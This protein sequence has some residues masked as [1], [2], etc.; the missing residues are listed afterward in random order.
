MTELPK[1]LP[2]PFSFSAMMSQLTGS[3]PSAPA[4]FEPPV[5]TPITKPLGESTIGVLVSCGVYHST[6]PPFQPL[7]DLSYRL[8]DRS[9]PIEE[10]T[11]G[12]PAAIRHFALQDLNVAYPRDRLLELEAEGIF[13]RL[14]NENVSILGAISTLSDL[15]LTTVPQI[16]DEF[17]RQGVDLVLLLPF[18]PA[19]HTSVSLVARA[20][21]TRG[22]PT[23]MTNCNWEAG[24]AIKA[25]RVAFLDFPMGCPAGKPN[26]PDLQRAVLRDT[27]RAA[28]GFS[29]P[30]EM[31]E[32]PYQW[33]SDGS[34]DWENEVRGLYVADAAGFAERRKT[35]GGRSEQL[36]GNE[37][38]FA[39]RCAC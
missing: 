18:C 38:D 15:L 24:Q 16:V 30:W 3:V 32:L 39:I 37:R 25:P 20:I 29:G 36:A 4:N 14:A 21:E 13:G 7:N 10:L 6:Q 5:R 31:L 22:L 9:I 2:R 11:L 33:S 35:L 23:V 12:H 26:D 8:I 34:R 17:V 1:T 28:S 19:C 27:L